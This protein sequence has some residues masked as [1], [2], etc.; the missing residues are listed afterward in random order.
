MQQHQYIPTRPS[1][2]G[3]ERRCNDTPIR[4]TSSFAADHPRRV[5]RGRGRP[6][7]D[8]SI[9]RLSGGDG[10]LEEGTEIDGDIDDTLSEFAD[11]W[12]TSRRC[13]TMRPSTMKKLKQWF[14]AYQED[15]D[16]MDKTDPNRADRCRVG[17]ETS[18]EEEIQEEI[19]QSQ[20][21]S[22]KPLQPIEHRD[23]EKPNTESSESK[24]QMTTGA[25]T[26]PDNCSIGFGFYC[27]KQLLLVVI[28][29]AEQLLPHSLQL[30]S[31]L[32]DKLK[33]VL[34]YLW[35]KFYRPALEHTAQDDPRSV[36]VRLALIPVTIIFALAYGAICMLHWLNRLF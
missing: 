28:F 31:Y 5:P 26:S 20:S 34:H 9:A 13:S 8:F 36:I 4:P 24:P 12:Y 29:L 27:L 32:Q 11:G 33:T 10:G 22:D 17:N 25:T 18:E 21:S 14:E 30:L 35:D 3:D 2:A 16:A 6:R 1:A 23:P 7:P 15:Q 19:H